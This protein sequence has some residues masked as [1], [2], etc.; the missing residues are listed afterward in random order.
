MKDSTNCFTG[1][2]I[3]LRLLTLTLAFPAIVLPCTAQIYNLSDNNSSAQVNVGSQTGLSQWSVE[4]Q[5]QLNQQWFWYGIGS[6][7][8]ASINTIGAASVTTPNSRTLYATYA[9]AQLSIEV[10]Y[11]LTGSSAGS[12]QSAM[13]EMIR[14]HN[15][16]SS[17]FT[18]HFY[19]YSDFNLAG[20][21][22]GDSVQMGK[23]LQ[24][25]FNEAYQSH[26]SLI[27]SETV[28]TPGANHGE[29]ALFGQTLGELNNGVTP[30]T[31]NDGLGVVGPGNVTW[32]L[33]WDLN[34]AAGGTALISK[35]SYLATPEPST[36]AIAGVGLGAFLLLRRRKSI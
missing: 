33:E 18:L 9:S 1:K 2:F 22:G 6:G 13:G 8:L 15:L 14:I 21:A 31:L 35:E 24:G 4:G 28:V 34:I 3:S 5:N 20:T 25:K 12:G 23:N 30:V 19:Q 27:M 36:F 32:A 29:V 26:G 7:P 17:A 16:S 10:D 11:T